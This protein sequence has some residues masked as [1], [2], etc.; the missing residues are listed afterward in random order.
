MQKRKARARPCQ[1]VD[2]IIHGTPRATRNYV[3]FQWMK[4]VN[5]GFYLEDFSA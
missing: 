3:A 1:K 2:V 4:S 5:T